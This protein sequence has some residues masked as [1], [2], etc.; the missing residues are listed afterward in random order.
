MEGSDLKGTARAQ[1]ARG[2]WAARSLYHAGPGRPPDT[3]ASPSPAPTPLSLPNFSVCAWPQLACRALR[4]RTTL[5]SFLYCPSALSR[6]RH[7]VTDSEWARETMNKWVILAEFKEGS[8]RCTRRSN[9]RLFSNPVVRESDELMRHWLD[10]FSAAGLFCMSN[11]LL[12]LSAI[13]FPC[14]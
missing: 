7:R 11:K 10:S 3:S 4:T 6:A 13:Q 2:L 14:R 1:S 12:N 5:E 9:G 8:V